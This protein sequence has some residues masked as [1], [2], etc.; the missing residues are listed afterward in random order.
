[1]LQTTD[2]KVTQLKTV[3]K[4]LSQLDDT[5]FYNGKKTKDSQ[6]RKYIWIKNVTAFTKLVDFCSSGVENDQ[7]LRPLLVHDSVAALSTTDRVSGPDFVF[8]VAL[9]ADVDHR[10]ADG[11]RGVG[12]SHFRVHFFKFAENFLENV[13]NCNIQTKQIMAKFVL[14]SK[15]A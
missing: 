13:R 1:M 8:G 15:Q 14:L 2:P 5:C 10:I 9:A 11:A 4:R 12:R 6:T 3:F 7:S